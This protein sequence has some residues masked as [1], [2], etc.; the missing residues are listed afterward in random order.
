MTILDKILATKREEIAAGMALKS[1]SVLLDELAAQPDARP[2]ADALKAGAPVGVIAE[3]KKASPSAGIIRHRFQPVEIALGYAAAGAAC[4]SVLTDEQYFGGKL[5]TI[6][7]V[8]RCT[9]CPILRKDF[10]VHPWQVAES[11]AAGADAILLIAAAL[12]QNELDLLLERA[13][14]LGMAALVEVHSVAEATVA[15][16]SGAEM[17][18]INNRNLATFETRLETTEEI[19]AALPQLRERM[20]VS[21]SGI[22]TAEDIQRVA[23]AGARAVLVG[24]ALM[25]APDPGAALQKLT[26]VLRS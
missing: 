18:G 22:R 21:E 11:R 15:L 25:R 19:T 26:D 12:Q 13:Q 10:I 8:R 17:I 2:F 20:L 5:A 1:E 3:I 16:A 4:I 7:A 9:A 6:A 14:Q 23:A 24:E